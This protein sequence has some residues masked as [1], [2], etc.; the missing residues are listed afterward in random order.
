MLY[1]FV[2]RGASTRAGSSGSEAN[3]RCVETL[4]VEPKRVYSLREAAEFCG[5]SLKMMRARADR[6]TMQT[7]MRNGERHVPHAELE[8]VGLLPDAEV[9]EL[10]R[11]L[12]LMHN[13]LATHRQLVESV[14]RDR[15]AAEEARRRV[16]QELHEQRAAATTASAQLRALEEQIARASWRERRELRKQLKTK[17]QKA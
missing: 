13:E 10:R 16:E 8:R 15:E 5:V 14:E 2:A 7:V 6:G 11:Q 4:P 9:H 12:E 1:P 17:L 3:I